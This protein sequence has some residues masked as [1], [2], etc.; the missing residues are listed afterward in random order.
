MEKELRVTYNIKS[1]AI[2]YKKII[3]KK[4]T[5]KNNFK[6]DIIKLF[7]PYIKRILSH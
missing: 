3:W 6:N 7:I 2:I 1:G 5:N 4:F